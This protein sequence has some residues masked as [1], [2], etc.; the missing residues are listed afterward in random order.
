M[1]MDGELD[2]VTM[3]WHQRKGYSADVRSETDVHAMASYLHGKSRAEIASSF[4]Q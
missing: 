1:L 2:R 4:S 3:K